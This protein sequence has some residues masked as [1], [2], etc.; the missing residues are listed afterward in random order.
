MAATAEFL[1]G[2]GTALGVLTVGPVSSAERRNVTTL[3]RRTGSAPVPLRTR[4][5]RVTVTSR[6]TDRWSSAIADN[7]KL[8]LT[9]RPAQAAPPPPATPQP[10]FGDDTRVTIR[11][12]AR[13]VRARGPLRALVVNANGFP[14]TGTLTARRGSGGRRFAV[15]ASGRAT[16]RLPLPRPLR[17]RLSRTGQARHAALGRRRGPGP[18]TA[19]RSRAGCR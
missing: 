3:L 8:T 18:A 19:A 17:R 14:V 10:A 7:V 1:D 16:V 4:E 2:S 15:A 13:R 9:S 12:A 5:I 6:D 11:L